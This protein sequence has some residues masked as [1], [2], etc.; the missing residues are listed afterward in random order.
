MQGVGNLVLAA[1]RKIAYYRILKQAN[2]FLKRRS[3]MQ[4]LNINALFL[5]L[6]G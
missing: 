5:G 6:A 2:H 1:A 4:K 3:I